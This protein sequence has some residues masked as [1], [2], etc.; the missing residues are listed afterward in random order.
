MGIPEETLEENGAEVL[1]TGETAEDMFQP[2][3]T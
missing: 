2:I 1:L 3:R